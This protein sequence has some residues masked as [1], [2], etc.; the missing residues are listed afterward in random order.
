[1]TPRAPDEGR[2]C[3]NWRRFVL[4]VVAAVA[5]LAVGACG[6]EDGQASPSPSPSGPVVLTIEG[7]ETTRT[8]TMNQLQA[9]PGYTGYA[10][11]KSSTGVITPPAEYTGVK[12]TDLTEMVGGI[13]KANGV[14][15]VAQDGY[16]MTFSYSQIVENAFTAYDPATGEE[17]PADGDLVV[18]VAYAREGESLGEDEGP[19][20][21]AVAEETPGQVVD[22]HWAIKW[23]DRI[24]VTKAS[25]RWE[26]QVQGATSAT[27]D[28]ANYVNCA[29]PGCHGSGWIDAEERRWEGVPLYLVCGM[30]DGG[31][32]HDAGA[33]RAGLAREG[34]DIE[35]ETANGEVVTVDSRDIAGRNDV[36]L[37][38][39]VDGG[40][41]PDEYFPLRLVGPGLGEDQ[42]AGGIVRIVVRVK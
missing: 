2:P 37:S 42:M 23:L 10:G 18:L 39:K 4:V 40:E 32:K 12:L 13:S 27:I 41:L 11:I 33:Y 29:S 24:S 14:T 31:R 16:G 17:E 1:M 28:R 30:V 22:G 36:L 9:L 5:V 15:I 19:L 8:F 38:S 26:V 7:E 6:G 21:L 35:F 34:Y 3:A 20:R 25:A